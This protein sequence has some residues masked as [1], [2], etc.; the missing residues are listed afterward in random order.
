MAIRFRVEHAVGVTLYHRAYVALG[1][2]EDKEKRRE[3]ERERE[4]DGKKNRG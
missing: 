2:L 1:T 4:R 3:R